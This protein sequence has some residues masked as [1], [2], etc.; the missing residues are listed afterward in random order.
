MNPVRERRHESAPSRHDQ[1]GLKRILLVEDNPYDVELALA[2]LEEHQLSSQVTVTHDGVEALDYLHG[3]G[4]YFGAGRTLPAVVL[5]D[6]KMPRMDG[7]EVLCHLK[8]DPELRR[9]PVVMLTSSR[10]EKDLARSYEL[11][12]NAYIVKPVDFTEYVRTVKELGVFWAVL[13]EPPP[14]AKPAPAAEADSP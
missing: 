7:L 11:G 14:H 3:R 10:E 12:V 5:L 4:R 1:A 2:A 9:L 13:N 8:K 6:L